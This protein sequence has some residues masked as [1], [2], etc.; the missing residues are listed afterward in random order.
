MAGVIYDKDG[1]IVGTSTNVDRFIVNKQGQIINPSTEELLID[2]KNNL[3]TTN[4]AKLSELAKE[5]TLS[6]INSKI[7]TTA[8]GIKVDGSNVIQPVNV[9]QSV[10]PQG[11]AT[12]YTLSQINNKL[13]SQN[14]LLK[15]DASG[16]TLTI[17]A[18]SLPLPSGAA[19]DSTLTDGSQKT[20]ITKGT[21]IANINSDGTLDVNLKRIDADIDLSYQDDSVQIYGYDGTTY[22]PIKVDSNGNLSVNINNAILPNNAATESTLSAIYS[23]ITGPLALENG[24]LA[25]IKNTVNTINNK[26]DNLARQNTLSSID[27]KLVKT[28]VGILIDGSQYTQNV[29][30]VSSVLPTNAAN[31]TNQQTIINKLN[32]IYNTVASEVT[33]AYINSKISVD[34]NNKIK[35][36][37]DGS[38]ITATVISSVLPTGAATD[39]TL[40]SGNAKFKILDNNGNPITST[41]GALDVNIK[42][43]AEIS[44]NLSAAND[45]VLIY[46]YNQSNGN[47]DPIKVDQNGFILINKDG[48]ATNTNQNVT[49][50]YL[51]EI[52]S[53]VATENT[54]AQINSK[55]SIDTNNNL[56][57]NVTNS[58]LNVNVISSVLPTGAAT[59][60]NQN[61]TNNL[62]TDIKNKI[63]ND[64]NGYLVIN[65]DGLA[66]SANQTQIYNI[67]NDKFD[68]NL[69]TRASETTLSNVNSNIVLVKNSVDTANTNIV[70]A[71]TPKATENTL[72]T[73]NSN[74]VALSSKLDEVKSSIINQL[75]WRVRGLFDN[76]GDPI[77]SILLSI[78]NK[79]GIFNISSILE[80]Y[81][82]FS[83]KMFYYAY[84]VNIGAGDTNLLALINPP[85][86]GK[87][88]L[89]NR[90]II[91]RNQDNSNGVIF[92][93]NFNANNV[94]GTQRTPLSTI[95][96]GT[97]SSILYTAPTATSIGS[98][99]FV[100]G[101][102]AYESSKNEDLNLEF[103][104][105]PGENLF[106]IGN[107]T[108]NGTPCYITIEW[109]EV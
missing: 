61:V 78:L 68:V 26:I 18:N 77:D 65:K 49:N 47:Y 104:L 84:S 24:N 37:A 48:L 22:K 16:T 86:S 46:G 30:V 35:V 60:A 8:N 45:S 106:I 33:L 17:S 20:Q 2:I 98:Q 91:A 42:S 64:S 9:T 83:K 69:S 7:Q 14:G 57:V 39:N 89:I 55:L 1:N 109:A 76:N 75:D 32:D 82:T 63:P 13:T 81:L 40:I 100:L 56:K 21:N 43:G 74:V 41:N 107:A 38:N 95:Q 51:N 108:A 52:N 53:K 87:I 36:N 72:Q 19:K 58:N 11:A 44:V 94:T 3:N 23:N 101:I 6:S 70:N 73:V 99:M 10:L 66:T 88:F 62:L 25:I 12:E 85:N 96:G 27:S 90:I 59:S 50:T 31:A 15:V 103:G 34:Q 5:N 97:S 92:R 67:L 93:I 79:R 4:D 105:N 54:L 102:N 80:Q 71:I 29:N 28:D